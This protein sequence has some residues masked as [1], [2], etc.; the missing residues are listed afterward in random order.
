MSTAADRVR[1]GTK[2]SEVLGPIEAA[3]SQVEERLGRQVGS[4]EPGVS[5]YVRYA[6]GTQGKRLRPALALLGGGA[7]GPLND[8]HITLAVIV[9]MIHLATLVHDDIMDG[10][11]MRRHKLTVSARWGNE[12]S[13]LLGDCLFAHALK[14]AT[15]FPDMEVCRRIAHATNVVCEGEILQTQRRFDLELSIE[16]YLK[17]VEM[18][19]A[20][21]FAVS[22]E[23]GA[24]LAGAPAPVKQSLRNYGMALGI[25]YQIYDDCVDIFEQENEAGKSLGTDLNKGKL[26]LPILTLLRRASETERDQISIDLTSY[27]APGAARLAALVVKHRTLDASLE[28]I[29]H[30]LDTA[31]DSLKPLP[32]SGFTTALRNLAFFLQSRSLALSGGSKPASTHAPAH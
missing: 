12:I 32:A 11:T 19:T 16:D 28:M 2:F 21:L 8:Y 31:L 22:C 25:A 14:L 10:A 24:F 9:E 1:G 27:S 26:T 17:F 18:K 29:E 5:D 15:D 7:C 23:L 6:L 4:F 30:Y 20:E 3:L 13:V